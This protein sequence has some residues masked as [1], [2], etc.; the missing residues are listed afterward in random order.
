MSDSFGDIVKRYL[1]EH[2]YTQKDLADSIGTSQATVSRAL[3]SSIVPPLEVA[4]RVILSLRDD[5]EMSW[6]EVEN[7]VQALVLPSEE[8]AKK[9]KDQPKLIG[10]VLPRLESYHYWGQ[11]MSAID[12]AADPRGVKLVVAQHD[13]HYDHFINDLTSF[14][15]IGAIRGVICAPPYGRAAITSVYAKSIQQIVDKLRQRRVPTVFIERYPFG[16]L[17][18]AGEPESKIKRVRYVGPSRERIVEECINQ[19]RMHGHTKI[20][21]LIDLP[22]VS[23]EAELLFHF[24]RVLGEDYNEEWV[25]TGAL[26]FSGHAESGD[27]PRNRFGSARSLMS[28][29]PEN[30]PSAVF[31]STQGVM[32]AAAQVASQLDLRVPE[33]I[34]IVGFD[35]TTGGDGVSPELPRISFDIS[36]YANLAVQEI[37][38]LIDDEEKRG[39][40]RNRKYPPS[41]L[42][43]VIFDHVRMVRPE[44]LERPE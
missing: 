35:P 12:R 7:L 17:T 30:R 13:N 43:P 10:L 1:R 14:L 2:S 38:R 31:C 18:A 39:F 15:E 32:R 36:G 3:K 42:D 33:D 19:L 40:S 24:K 28:L 34:A 11:L 16:S 5:F 41:P 25:R 23:A 27:D 26:N 37:W 22:W 29:P 20:G 6:A 8:L 9:S 4:Q 44:L 21:I